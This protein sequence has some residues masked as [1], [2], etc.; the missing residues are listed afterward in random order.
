M[1]FHVII[2]IA[3]DVYLEDIMSTKLNLK[4]VVYIVALAAI[5]IILGL[6]EIPWFVISGPFASFLRLDFSEVAIL[7]ALITLGYKDT[8]MVVIL[9][10]FVRLSFKGFIP[11]NIIGDMISMIA[12]LSIILGFFMATKIRHIKTTP[13][14]IEVPSDDVKLN[15]KNYVVFGFFITLSLSLFMVILNFFVTTP[16]LLSYY[17][18]TEK[19]TFH[20]FDFVAQTEYSIQSFLW[21]VIISYTP[22]NI[23]KGISVMVI[24]LIIWPRLKYIEY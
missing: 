15:Y 22:F 20:V 23:V 18:F 5:S 11:E 13:Y 14:L 6:F 16:L 21:A 12:S 4:R 9:R 24:F 17:G 10:S 19:L 7:V 2:S 1:I 3:K 8:L